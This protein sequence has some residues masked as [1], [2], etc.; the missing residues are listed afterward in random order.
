MF[1]WAIRKGYIRNDYWLKFLQGLET[2]PA[3]GL[4]TEK[5]PLAIVE[6]Y[7]SKGNKK[8]YLRPNYVLK[9]VFSIRSPYQLW[10]QLKMAKAIFLGS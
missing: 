5:L 3:P 9:R 6:K 8:F 10:R 7:V 1:E 2:N 4:E